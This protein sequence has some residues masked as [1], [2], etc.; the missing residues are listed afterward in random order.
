V[1]PYYR[2]ESKAFFHRICNRSTGPSEGLGAG[3]PSTSAC[4]MERAAYAHRA[5]VDG[6]GRSSEKMRV[7][8]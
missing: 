8:E 3:Q 6:L 7:Y 1:L 4:S 2:D 5:S